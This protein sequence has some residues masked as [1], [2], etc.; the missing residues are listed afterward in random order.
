MTSAWTSD[1]IGYS[2][3]YDS[4]GRTVQQVFKID[5]TTYPLTYSYNEV[6]GCGCP[7]S[8]LQSMTYPDGL[9]VNYT[10]DAASRIIGISSP[11]SGS[12]VSSASYAAAD[13]SLSRVDLPS[14]GWETYGYA[15]PGRVGTIETYTSNPYAPKC[16]WDYTYSTA[17]RITKI[18]EHYT[19]NYNSTYSTID[20]TY[21]NRSMLNSATHAAWVLCQ[22]LDDDLC[23]RPVREHTAD[24]I[25]RWL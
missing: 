11:Q 19:I 12:F 1:G 5:G 20:Y 9:Q 13:G 3:N 22:R 15:G 25:L 8:D 16:R 17:G 2:W 23:L 6:G 18:Y 7:K 21:N 14:Y 10:R 4:S 24:H